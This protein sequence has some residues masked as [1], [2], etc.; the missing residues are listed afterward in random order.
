MTVGDKLVL[1][2]GDS[3]TQSDLAAK[4]GLSVSLISKIEQ[5]T[6]QNLKLSSIRSL[7]KVFNLT[8]SQ[9]LEGVE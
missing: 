5:N 1:L 9:L 6:N 7:A 4:S 3:M 2:R 8:I